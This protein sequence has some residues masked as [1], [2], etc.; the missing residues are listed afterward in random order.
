MFFIHH[1][2]KNDEWLKKG[3]MQVA[4]T[5][6]YLQTEEVLYNPQNPVN[7]DSEPSVKDKFYLSNLF[8]LDIPLS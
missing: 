7:P 6:H 1:G 5:N 2:I 4:P 3:R 8:Y